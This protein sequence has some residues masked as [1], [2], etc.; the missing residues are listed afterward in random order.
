MAAD[1]D[2]YHTYDEYGSV[3]SL[4]ISLLFFHFLDRFFEIQKNISYQ[5]EISVCLAPRKPPL[6]VESG[7]LFSSRC[8]SARENCNIMSSFSTPA[9]KSKQK[10]YVTPFKT[11]SAATMNSAKAVD[12][13]RVLYFILLRCITLSV[14]LLSQQVV[15]SLY[16]ETFYSLTHLICKRRNII[17]LILKSGDWE[18]DC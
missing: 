11:P 16:S 5:F 10:G 7:V 15:L 6:I 3:L 17:F 9:P 14:L 18:N 4:V 12:L 8:E 13:V 2:T 1:W